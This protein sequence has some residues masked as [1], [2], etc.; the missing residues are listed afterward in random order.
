MLD[1]YH[2]SDSYKDYNP[3]YYMVGRPQTEEWY[4]KDKKNTNDWVNNIT[5]H[6]Y[7]A[8]TFIDKN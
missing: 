7:K 5:C 4:D 3:L 1:T 8:Y 6:S 2:D